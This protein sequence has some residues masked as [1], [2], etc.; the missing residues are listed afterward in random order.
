[1]TDAISDLI[2]P[3]ERYRRASDPIIP[4]VSIFGTINE[5]TAFS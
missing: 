1:L 5:Y 4:H 2:L 3:I